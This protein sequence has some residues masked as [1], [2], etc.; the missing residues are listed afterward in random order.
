MRHDRGSEGVDG[1]A[2]RWLVILSLLAA[3]LGW[4]WAWV[5][6]RDTV[7]H[8]D[9][10]ALALGRYIMA[11]LALLP[12]WF[13]RDRPLPCAR[14]LPIVGAMGL[15]GFTFYNL[16]I[17]V[18]EKTITAGTAALI[19][20]CIPVMVTIGGRVFFRERLTSAGWM[21]VGIALFGL[22]VITASAEGGLRLSMG[23]V[24]VLL[25]S[26]CA[27][28]YGLISKRFL[29]RNG[30]LETTTWAIWAGTVGLIPTGGGLWDAVVTAPLFATVQ[31]ALLGVIPGAACYALLNY[32]ISK[33]ALVKVASW[34][35]LIPVASIALGWL[36]LDEMPPPLVLVGG[37][38]T[39]A[40]VFL[41][42]TRGE[43]QFAS[44]S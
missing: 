11:S 12:F 17:N 3:V 9:P 4:G 1:K 30:W 35:F 20:A 43:S 18:G 21:G 42:N 44:R 25:A 26:V 6:I 40:G 14:D 19:A 24:L 27:A 33:M 23:A 16:L 37:M 41:V 34:M 2:G 13:L 10:G 8:Y 22:V 38:I 15:L 32:A 7:R 31:V 39:L 5:G 28:G 29:S 36:L